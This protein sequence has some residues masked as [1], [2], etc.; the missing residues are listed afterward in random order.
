MLNCCRQFIVSDECHF[1]KIQDIYCNANFEGWNDTRQLYNMTKY[2]TTWIILLSLSLRKSKHTRA[3]PHTHK[4]NNTTEIIKIQT[5]FSAIFCNCICDSRFNILR[6]KDL[7]NR[8]YS[9][10]F[11]LIRY[12]E[13]YAIIERSAEI[14][15]YFRCSLVALFLCKEYLNMATNYI[16]LLVKSWTFWYIECPPMWLYTGVIHF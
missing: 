4:N 1:Y 11:L 8:S 3:H 14:N 2:Q 9:W 5:F 6:R 15:W 16:L 10:N 7:W 12:K 13:L